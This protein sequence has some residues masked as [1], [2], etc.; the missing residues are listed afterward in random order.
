MAPSPINLQGLVDVH[1]PK[2]YKFIGFGDIPRG[3]PDLI[4]RSGRISESHGGSLGG[5]GGPG[6]HRP[7]G[8]RAERRWPSWGCLSPAC[9]NL[10]TTETAHRL[11]DDETASRLLTER[12]T[13]RELLST[14]PESYS[15]CNR[16]GATPGR[17]CQLPR[18]T[19]LHRGCSPRATPG[20]TDRE[21][22]PVRENEL[23]PPPRGPPDLILRSGLIFWV[24]WGGS[25]GPRGPGKAFKNVATSANLCKTPPLRF[26]L[27]P[28]SPRGKQT[29]MPHR[30]VAGNS[31]SLQFKVSRLISPAFHQCRRTVRAS[32]E[33]GCRF[34]SSKNT[35]NRGV[36]V[37]T[38]HP[39][40][41]P[42]CFR[43]MHVYIYTPHTTP[44][45]GDGEQPIL[46]EPGRRFISPGLLFIEAD[47]LRQ[48]P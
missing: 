28:S 29:G 2:P 16:P 34:G 7:G 1:G 22:L 44:K 25:G 10:L 37:V 5:P 43:H 17:F 30:P 24:S 40:A 33:N 39:S 12:A 15:R 3:P 26:V 19:R 13:H 38:K 23:G 4:L 8:G 27:S 32:P 48:R 47:P 31:H 18:I 9:E 21:L 46:G 11:R 14:T 41:T 42:Q 6:K 36:L 45:A 35:G 20:A